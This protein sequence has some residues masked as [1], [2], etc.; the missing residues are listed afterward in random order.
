MTFAF[1]VTLA[2]VDAIT[3]AM[4]DALYEAGCDDAG[5]GS[6]AGV[7]TIDFDREAPSLGQAIDS[8]LAD[9]ARA[10]YRVARVAT[11]DLAPVD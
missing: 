2:E 3:D 11:M 4:T 10:G 8:A 6:C 9:I 1:R 5:V 7:V